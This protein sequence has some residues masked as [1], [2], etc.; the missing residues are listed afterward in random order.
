MRRA[1][2]PQIDAPPA[3]VPETVEAVASEVE[4]AGA[5]SVET[6][7]VEEA[8]ETELKDKGIDLSSVKEALAETTSEEK[9]AEPTETTE[10]KPAEPVEPPTEE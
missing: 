9:P 7:A 10:E 6:K 4:G 1:D 3:E 2:E 8:V 5:S